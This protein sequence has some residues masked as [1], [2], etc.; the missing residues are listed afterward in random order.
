MR[1]LLSLAAVLSLTACASNI[2]PLVRDGHRADYIT[3]DKS[4]RM[5]TLW[6]TGR[7]LKTYNIMSLGFNP[8]GHKMEEG[9]GRTPEGHYYINEKHPSQR[10]QKFLNISYPNET[11]IANAYSLGVR[12]GG[13]VGIHGDKGGKEGFKD[14]Q[15]NSWTL[16]C[17]SVRNKEIEEIYQLVPVGTEIFIQP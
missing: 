3:I 8:L 15:S 17:I 14:R 11:D 1:F 10:F 16:G 12:P 13:S 9:D 4:D 7:P 5:L 2:S 6:E